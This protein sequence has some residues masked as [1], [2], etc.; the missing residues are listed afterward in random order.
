MEPLTLT[1]FEV[2]QLY[3]ALGT[4]GMALLSPELRTKIKDSFRENRSRDGERP[5]A[6]PYEYATD[7]GDPQPPVEEPPDAE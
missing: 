2:G 4:K 3:A 5:V 1:A 6:D 7:E